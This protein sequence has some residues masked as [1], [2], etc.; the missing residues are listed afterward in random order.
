MSDYEGSTRSYGGSS[1]SRLSSV[2]R[3][4]SP[5]RSLR[6]SRYDYTPSYTSSYSAASADRVRD[7][8][9]EAERKREMERERQRERDRERERE[10]ERRK[11]RERE[12]EERER[13]RAE[14][15]RERER[16]NRERTE[17][18]KERE[19]AQAERA[20]SYSLT[21]FSTRRSARA[22]DTNLTP[23]PSR[24]QRQISDDA[25]S[26][27]VERQTSREGYTRQNSSGLLRSYSR[28]SS[29]DSVGTY[30]RQTSREI[31][32]ESEDSSEGVV[33]MDIPPGRNM[34]YMT[35]RPTSPMEPMDIEG[36]PIKK[37]RKRNIS[38]KK[39]KTYPARRWRRGRTTMSTQTDMDD[40]KQENQSTIDAEEPYTPRRSR[41]GSESKY[42]YKDRYGS[43]GSGFNSPYSSS[44]L[45][46]P[47]PLKSPGTTRLPSNKEVE[48]EIQNPLLE[49][50]SRLMSEAKTQSL[51]A[52]RKME[53]TFESQ[54]EDDIPR[55]SLNRQHSRSS[56]ASARRRS[57][58]YRHLDTY[59]A[60]ADISAFEDDTPAPPKQS[61]YKS[62]YQRRPSYADTT[63]T[64]DVTSMAD[65]TELESSAYE[66][67]SLPRKPVQSQYKKKPVW[68]PPT[69]SAPWQTKPTDDKKQ[70]RKSITND[71]NEDM[72]DVFIDEELFTPT[73]PLTPE[74]LSL[75][76]SIE[77]VKTW[78]KQLQESPPITP[79]ATSPC[80]GSH[81]IPTVLASHTPTIKADEISKSKQSNTTSSTTNKTD[82][83][84]RR[85]EP[86]DVTDNLNKADKSELKTFTKG[87]KS[88]KRTKPKWTPKVS[89]PFAK[90]LTQN[91]STK[92]NKTHVKAIPYTESNDTNVINVKTKEVEKQNQM[93]NIENDEPK[94]ILKSNKTHEKDELKKDEIPHTPNE[95]IKNN[96]DITNTDQNTATSNETLPSSLPD[97]T[98]PTPNPNR[99]V[100]SSKDRGSRPRIP[101]FAPPA[102]SIS[103]LDPKNKSK[104]SQP[105]SKVLFARGSSKPSNAS[106]NAP[107]K[108]IIQEE[109]STVAIATINSPTTESSF[110]QLNDTNIPKSKPTDTRQQKKNRIQQQLEKYKKK[111][112]LNETQVDEKQSK[113]NI[114]NR[115]NEQIMHEIDQERNVE[116]AKL[117]K[118]INDTQNLED[119]ISENLEQMSKLNRDKVSQTKPSHNDSPVKREIPAASAKP[120]DE[121]EKTNDEI[122]LE[123]ER[124]ENKRKLQLQYEAA[125]KRQSKPRPKWKPKEKAIPDMETQKQEMESK[126]VSQHPTP[127]IMDSGSKFNSAM[128]DSEIDLIDLEGDAQSDIEK[129]EKVHESANEKVK[130]GDI[131]KPKPRH[132]KID[133]FM[134]VFDPPSVVVDQ[135]EDKH[136][137]LPDDAVVG[138]DNDFGRPDS[139]MSVDSV[140]N[141]RTHK[142]SRSI[143]AISSTS[144]LPDVIPQ[145]EIHRDLPVPEPSQNRQSVSPQPVFIGKVRDIDSLLG[146]D[147]EDDFEDF[148]DEEEELNDISQRERTFADYHQRVDNQHKTHRDDG[149]VLERIIQSKIE[150]P[151]AFSYDEESIEP[152]P[153]FISDCQNIDDLLGDVVDFYCEPIKVAKAKCMDID[154]LLGLPDLDS[155][156][157]EDFQQTKRHHITIP[158]QLSK[159]M[160]DSPESI[161]DTPVPVTP[162]R[163][164]QPNKFFNGRKHKSRSLDDADPPTAT[165]VDISTSDDNQSKSLDLPDGDLINL[166]VNL[167]AFG[168][169][170]KTPI[171]DVQPHPRCYKAVTDALWCLEDEGTITIA[172]LLVICKNNRN[173]RMDSESDDRL[174]SGYPTIVDLLENQGIDVHKVTF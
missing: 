45:A 23:F 17:R 83:T 92:S 93:Q 72:D 57:R 147:T 48:Y 22:Q 29:N 169:L 14:R 122:M 141:L 11:M 107:K 44:S 150:M 145:H 32:L 126:K 118:G 42:R 47:S 89:S 24:F 105:E 159:D 80:D 127:T 39:T 41:F 97:K 110:D 56:L 51:K 168:N 131:G 64:D 149:I 36:D 58:T 68:K 115:T 129:D 163:P 79:S 155:E 26:P 5:P 20:T 70:E 43:Y 117:Q 31:P 60:D 28:Q 71:E 50:H 160:I 82:T 161:L 18:E 157:E 15:E 35:S 84:Q 104:F 138:Q 153:V 21:P 130:D 67:D 100:L 154:E 144:S 99:R 128:N 8:E 158:K 38:K 88:I 166:H 142:R 125:K 121:D 73:I 69:V 137:Q 1:I 78:K 103:K 74:N 66:Y 7:K 53:S 123:L 132:I 143:D 106:R 34:K 140:D 136:N 95:N 98:A 173:A 62:R 3:D 52:D 87:M 109:S 4:T 102:M 133:R 96:H 54:T 27:T 19:K 120:I 146:F 81:S 30:S 165:L 135:I 152:E 77:K 172:D 134:P 124:E 170:P 113:Q 55:I 167:P 111:P 116:K 139:V 174:F 114:E 40:D 119:Q 33:D 112:L 25:H 46:S 65:T 164:L 91:D 13:I 90:G 151:P 16:R 75:K 2:P 76:E 12:R 85:D 6:S 148:S 9:R 171:D 37:K 63:A 108:H 49:K 162:D 86:K 156:E 10:A 101:T 59:D 94:E 61:S